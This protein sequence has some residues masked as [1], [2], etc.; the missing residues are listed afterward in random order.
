MKYRAPK[1]IA[2]HPGVEV[3]ESGDAEGFDYKH[4]VWL[5]EGWTFTYGRMAGCRSGNFQT[6]KAFLNAK[7][8]NVEAIA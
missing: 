5:R 4:S 6:V 1:A 2:G 7:A 8:A 3:C